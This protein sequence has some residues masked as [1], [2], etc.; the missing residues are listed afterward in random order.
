MRRRGVVCLDVAWFG[1]GRL[2]SGRTSLAFFEP[3]RQACLTDRLAEPRLAER[4][5]ALLQQVCRRCD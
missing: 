5:G 4:L 2:S 3:L 1:I